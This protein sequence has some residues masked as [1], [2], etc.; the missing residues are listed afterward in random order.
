M[1]KLTVFLGIVLLLFL[2]FD[3][4]LSQQPLIKPIFAKVT[5]LADV[6]VASHTNGYAL[7]W[8]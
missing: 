7:V 6:S 1:K 5:D 8:N 3:F 4:T 2:C